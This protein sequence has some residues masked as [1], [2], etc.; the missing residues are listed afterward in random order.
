MSLDNRITRYLDREGIPY[1]L[2]EHPSAR[3]EAA[4]AEAG[5]PADKLLR[6][7]VLQHRQGLLVAVLPVNYLIDFVALNARL[8]SR[9]RPL[10]AGQLD[11]LFSDCEEGCVAPFGAPYGLNTAVDEGIAAMGEVYIPAGDT[12]HLLAIDGAQLAAIGNNQPLGRISHRP[13]PDKARQTPSRS[14]RARRRSEALKQLPPLP[15]TGRRLLMLRNSAEPDV[16]KLADIVAEDPSVSAQLLAYARSAYFG[17]GGRIHDVSDAITLVLGYDM[18]LSTAMALTAAAPYKL[19]HSGRLG[20]ENYWR[21]SLLGAT[22]AQSL[23][24]RL[25]RD[26]GVNPAQAYLTTLLRDI[27][28]LVMG[29]VMEEDYRKLAEAAE[30]HPQVP[31][32]RLEKSLLGFGHG[33]IGGWVLRRWE[34]PEPLSVVAAE[35]HNPGYS[36]EH[37]A[38]VALAQLVDALLENAEELPAAALE[39][40]D[41][42]AE[43]ARHRAAELLDGSAS[44]AG[45]A[46]QLAA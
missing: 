27:G 45:Y 41:I 20:L 3:P 31:I 15:L 21:S 22:L 23:A 25:P 17:Y 38:Y 10:H 18:A 43:T 39:L 7:Q 26:R 8:G 30:K 5:L 4:M 34:L 42:D 35:H 40:L 44:L 14:E 6:V 29:Q 19:P 13:I 33:Q 37:A 32:S 2:I 12:R 28:L 11:R 9:P 46:R 1:R 16:S 24:A 36:G